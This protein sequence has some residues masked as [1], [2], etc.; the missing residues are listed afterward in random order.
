MGVHSSS[1]PSPPMKTF[2]CLLVLM[3]GVEGGHVRKYRYHP[4]NT[5]A[6][7]EEYI[8]TLGGT[9]NSK[10]IHLDHASKKSTF[11]PL[12]PP[13]IEISFLSLKTT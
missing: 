7:P 12:T 9:E 5:K 2:A 13:P 11:Y 3:N 6:N 10:Y 8:F 1:S 4:K